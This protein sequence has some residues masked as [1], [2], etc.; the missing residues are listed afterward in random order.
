MKPCCL[1]PE[2]ITPESINTFQIWEQ[3]V[4]S[5]I[6]SKMNARLIVCLQQSFKV[7][8]QTCVHIPILFINPYLSNLTFKL[9]ACYRHLIWAW[10]A[11]RTTKVS[12][13]EWDYHQTTT[14]VYQR[15]HTHTGWQNGVQDNTHQTDIG[16]GRNEDDTMQRPNTVLFTRVSNSLYM[17]PLFSQSPPV[18]C[19]HVALTTSSCRER[20]SSWRKPTSESSN[21]PARAATHGYFNYWFIYLLPSIVFSANPNFPKLKVTSSESLSVDSLFSNSAICW[22]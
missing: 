5:C 8:K 22:F 9:I 19:L 16:K 7:T 11:L 15:R 20:S 1:L 18:G 13:W 4:R 14:R 10:A 2:S 17:P 21:E 6:K 12:G 3:F